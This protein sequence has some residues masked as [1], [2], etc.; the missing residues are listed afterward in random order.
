M[1][2]DHGET[3][4]C[5]A[6]REFHP[7]MFIDISSTAVMSAEIAMKIS[8]SGYRFSASA[9]PRIEQ[10]AEVMDDETAKVRPEI[11]LESIGSTTR[12]K[13]KLHPIRMSVPKMGCQRN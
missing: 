5:Q 10:S 9:K 6:S 13:A 7:L 12:Q 1:I 2:A 8:R 3:H 4:H 11:A